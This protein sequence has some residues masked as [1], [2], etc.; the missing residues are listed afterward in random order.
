MLEAFKE[1]TQKLR[2][3]GRAVAA[4]GRDS[5]AQFHKELK[6]CTCYQVHYCSRIILQLVNVD[7]DL[8][9][10]DGQINEATVSAE[11]MTMMHAIDAA[12]NNQWRLFTVVTV[13]RGPWCGLRRSTLQ[14]FRMLIAARRN[15]KKLWTG[16]LHVLMQHVP[17]PSYAVRGSSLQGSSLNDGRTLETLIQELK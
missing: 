10:Q 14:N 6:R 11:L 2:Q 3:R 8:E 9:R 1:N 17:L 15:D 4:R 13:T 7:A 16:E 5:Y 12:N